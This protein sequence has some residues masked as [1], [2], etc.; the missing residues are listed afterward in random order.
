MVRKKSRRKDN[1]N[2]DDEINWL[3]D[4]HSEAID[5]AVA[6]AEENA[7]LRQE[8]TRLYEELAKL[9]QEVMLLQKESLGHF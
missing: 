5:H 2:S 7:E 6:L 1:T 8:N 3:L 9:Q 4:A